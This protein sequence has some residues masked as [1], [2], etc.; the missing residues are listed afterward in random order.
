MKALE[1]FDKA[2]QCNPQDPD[3][4]YNKGLVLTKLGR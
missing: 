3:F 4:F 1:Y 2:I